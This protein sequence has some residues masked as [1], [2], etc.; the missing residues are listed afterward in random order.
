MGNSASQ[1]P[2]SIDNQVG[3]PH[4]HHGWALHNGK[5]TDGNDT[6]VSVFVG[7]K[8]QLAKLAVSPRFP[9]QTQFIP[10]LHHYNYCRKLRHPHILKVYATLDTDNPT[11]ASSTEG[12]AS[13]NA[14]AEASTSSS[15]ATIGDLIIVTEPCVSLTQWLLSNPTPEQLAWGLECLV[16]GL[17]FLHSSAKLVH[18]NTSPSSFYVTQSGDVKLWNFSLVTQIGPNL[19]PSNHFQQWEQAC[20]PDA[21]RSPERVEKRWDALS[22]S[23]VHAMDSFGLGILMNE[24]F[25]HGRVPAPLQKAVQ[26]LLTPN[27]KMRPR[28]QP[29][30]KCPVF[31][32]PY[33]KLQLSLEEIVV[34]PV[35]QKIYLWQNLGTSLQNGQIPKDV[36]LHKVL[37]LIQSSIRHTCANDSML[38]QDL[39]RREGKIRYKKKRGWCY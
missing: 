4:D 11:A 35:E 39:Y 2:Y 29:L 24:W 36:A 14:A 15:K 17:H 7:K 16:R 33:Q 9:N 31:D 23:G 27:L 3:A 38:G 21:Y 6:E 13:A 34:Q 1:L 18:G 32:T 37:P 20:T 30:L 10:A 26:R 28:L 8:P 19:G 22:N 5:S 12:S 25:P